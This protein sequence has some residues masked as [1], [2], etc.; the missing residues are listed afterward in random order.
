[1]KTV[2]IGDNV[3]DM[4]SLPFIVAEVGVNH[5]GDLNMAYKMIELAKEA[6]ASAVKFQTFKA[7]EFVADKSQTYTY[8]SQGKDVTE[9]MYDMFV[10]YE[11]SIE[12]WRLIKNKCDEVGIM[13][14]ST[15]QNES[16]LQILLDLG[17][18]AIKVGSDDFTNIPLLKNYAKTGLPLIV[19]MGMAD[20]AEVYISLASIGSLDGYPTI[21]LLCTSQYPTPPENVNLN[22]LKTLKAAFPS[23]VFGFSDHTQGSLASSL[24][25]AAG[26]VFFEKHFT[27]DHNLPGPD[28]WF[29]EDPTGLKLWIEQIKLAHK[30]LGSEIIRPTE[31]E[32]KI[33]GI[34]RRSIVAKIDINAGEVLSLA[35]L[36]LKRPGT[37]LPPVLFDQVL[38][39]TATRDIQKNTILSFGDMKSITN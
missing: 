24:A 30:M 32:I 36:T 16:D 18:N 31:S 29:S 8:N 6:G 13:F 27:L 39:L 37:G 2:K 26:A 12:E 17:V 21:L 23:L 15:P 22:K 11:F 33:K 5:N 19:S 38:G 25:V 34:A 35:N 7:E 20:L 14:L 10:R 28:H 1:M 3:L 4:T 9:S